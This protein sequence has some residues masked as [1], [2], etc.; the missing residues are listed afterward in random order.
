MKLKCR[1]SGGLVI[2]MSLLRVCAAIKGM[3]AKQKV[4]TLACK[5][6]SKPKKNTSMRCYKIQK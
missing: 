1:I 2:V 5:V 4:L 3:T 6:K